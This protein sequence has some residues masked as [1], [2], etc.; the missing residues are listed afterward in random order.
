[1][2]Q[3]MTQLKFTAAPLRPENIPNLVNIDP[4]FPANL[5]FD[6]ENT[7]SIP[8]QWGTTGL[9]NKYPVCHRRNRHMGNSVGRTL[10][11]AD[12]RAG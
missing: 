3:I 1:M 5:P 9:A 10:S 2:V 11:R 4:R 6:P 12:F 8:Y 7:Y